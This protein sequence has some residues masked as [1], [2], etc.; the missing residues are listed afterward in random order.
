MS[1]GEIQVSVTVV[2]PAPD[3]VMARAKANMIQEFN[4]WLDGK[5]RLRPFA[6]LVAGSFAAAF[7][8]EAVRVGE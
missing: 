3:A 2:D 7:V 1:V 4:D 5:C 6:D 8:A